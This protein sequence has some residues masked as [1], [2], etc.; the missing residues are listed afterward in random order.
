MSLRLKTIVGI[1]CIELLLLIILVVQSLNFLRDSNEQMLAKRAN[2]S[3][4]LFAV[5]AKDAV[6]ATDLTTLQTFVIKTLEHTD[7]VYVRVVGTTEILAAGGDP[8]VLATPFHAD[9]HVADVDDGVFDVAVDVVEA[10]RHFGRVEIGFSTEEISTLLD[11]ARPRIIAIAALEVVLVAVFSFLLG[12]YLMRRLATLERAAFTIAD[13]GAGVQVEVSG[14]DELA[15][16]TH[17]FNRMSRT[18]EST[19][20]QLGQARDI[21][22]AASRAKSRFLAVMSHEIRTPL[23]G[24]LGTMELLRDTKLDEE[25]SSY[26]QASQSAGQA[27]MTLINDTLDY[28]KIEE[29]KLELNVT[30][31][32]IDDVVDE[33]VGLLAPI[34]AGKG[35]E[36]ATCIAA[37][38]RMYGDAHRLRQV[39]FNLVGNAVKFTDEGGVTVTVTVADDGAG[40]EH[41]DMAFEIEDTGIGIDAR[42]VTRLF[43]EFTQADTSNSRR[44]GGTGLGLAISRRLVE[45]MGGAITVRSDLGRGSTFRFTAVL[46]GSADMNEERSDD[47]DDVAPVGRVLICARHPIVR[48]MLSRQLTAM[49]VPVIASATRADALEQL[50]APVDDRAPRWHGVI[51]DIHTDDADASSFIEQVRSAPSI[52]E[53]ARIIVASDIAAIGARASAFDVGDV[54]IDGWLSKP[55]GRRPLKAALFPTLVHTSAE[56]QAS[57]EHASSVGLS[58]EEHRI[59]L[60]EDNPINRMVVVT[61]LRAAGYRVD[62]VENGREAVEATRDGSYALVLMDMSMPLMGGLDATREIRDL[63]GAASSVPIVALTANALE[64]ERERCLQAGMDAYLTKPVARDHLLQTIRQYALS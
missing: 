2:L 28:T 39:L 4:N 7:V 3:A 42:E 5:T 45:A 15:R 23:S 46:R 6:I 64:S 30:A 52:G 48:A 27:L 49:S 9:S 20:E 25:Q 57:S 22:E 58:V 14:N 11:H 54:G 50:A 8:R 61:M 44:Y 56:P 47:G 62:V 16:T 21:A 40:R 37:P 34:A 59:L 55:I 12:T 1:A 13:G 31:F 43:E 63:S 38:T 53:R 60:A 24:L 18:L 17:A 19:H 35:I 33:V 36:L 10:G 41:I 26:V 51:L 32:D 29:G